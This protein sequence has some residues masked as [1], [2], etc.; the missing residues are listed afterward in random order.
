M[1]ANSSSQ[2][3]L[4]QPPGTVSKILW[5]FTGGPRWNIGK[6]AQERRPKPPSEAYQALTSIFRTKQLRLGQ[7]REVLKVRLPKLRRYNPK[8]KRTEELTNILVELTSAPVCCLADIPVAHLSYQAR[9]YGTMAIGF[10]RGA[11]VRHGFNPVFYTLH[12]TKVLRSVYEGFAKLK[13]ASAISLDDT[14]WS[15][16]SDLKTLEREYSHEVD[17]SSRARRHITWEI[18]DLRSE[19]ED[20][21]NAIT[22]AQ[23]SLQKFLAFVKTFDQ[24]EFSTIY[25]EREWRS[26]MQFTFTVDDVAMIVLPKEKASVAYFNQFVTR[27]ARK[28]RIPRSTPVVPW[29][30]LIEH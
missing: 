15:L 7:Y 13:Q 9:R 4:Q 23:T 8:R 16:S 10:H 22:D 3:P 14:V 12:D 6:K 27:D 17:T 1:V 18:D 11:T 28:L 24:E 5:H 21:A 2:R 29:E 26:T 20:I 30:D 25:C 19:A